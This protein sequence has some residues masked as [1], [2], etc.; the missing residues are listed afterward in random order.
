MNLTVTPT[1][2]PTGGV[3]VIPHFGGADSCVANTNAL[4][5]PSWVT[6]N[7]GPVLQPALLDH[8]KLSAIA[9][10]IGLV[11]ALAAALVAF[12]NGWFSR[13][14]AGFAAI[15]YTIPSLAFFELFVPVTGLGTLTIEIGLVGY[16][17]LILFRNTLEGLRSAPPEVVAA[18]VGMGMTPRQIFFRVNMRLAIPAIMAGVR[19]ATVTTISLATIAAYISPLGLGAPILQAIQDSFNTEL[20]MAGGLAIVLALAAD[21]AL[22]LAERAITPWQRARR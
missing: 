13:G 16:T 3:P 19:V 14:F 2:T 22:V 21:G 1:P 18:A 15:L 8:I 10:A 7:W 12:R 11:I 20:I 17:L 5:C 9:V 4:F 6:K